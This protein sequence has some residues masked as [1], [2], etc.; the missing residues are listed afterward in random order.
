MTI[1]LQDTAIT[2]ETRAITASRPTALRR[3][4]HALRRLCRDQRG[5]NFV[6]YGV[7]VALVALAGMTF[8]PAFSGTI[9]TAFDNL[10][11]QVKEIGKKP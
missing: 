3:T 7:L 5:A 1:R 10:G 6:E 8:L 11:N 9:K 2:S 4:R